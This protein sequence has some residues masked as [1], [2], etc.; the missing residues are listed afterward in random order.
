MDIG[1]GS[2]EI[3]AFLGGGGGLACAEFPRGVEFRG[4]FAPFF[5]S[6][7]LQSHNVFETMSK[8]GF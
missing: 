6:T 3:P 2:I 4:S 7:S 5:F 8:R 1:A